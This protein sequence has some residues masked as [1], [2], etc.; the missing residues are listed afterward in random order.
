VNLRRLLPIGW[1][2]LA[3]SPAGAAGE[4][5]PARPAARAGEFRLPLLSQNQQTGLLTGTGA[6]T[7]PDGTVFLETARVE[8]TYPAGPTNV[9]LVIRATRCLV[10]LRQ[11]RVSSAEAL[12]VSTGDGQLALE[13]VG[14]L[15]LQATSELVVSNQ[16]RTR[17]RKRPSGADSEDARLAIEAGELHLRLAASQVEFRRRVRVTDPDLEVRAERLTA[18]R[19]PAGRFDRLEVGGDV[20]I[21]SRRDGSRTTS[22]RA[23]YRLTAE[24]EVVELTGRPHWTDSVRAA[25][26][27]RFL[28]ERDPAADRQVLRALGDAWIL[29]PLGTHSPGGWPLAAGAAAPEPPP[30]AERAEARLSAEALTL[31]LPPTPGPVQ[32]LRAETNVV[33][34]DPAG[35]WRATAA[36]AGFT[37]EVLELTGDPH[38]HSR[39]RE[40]RGATL[41]LNLPQRT[42]EVLGGAR[43]RLPVE[44]FEPVQ[45]GPGPAAGTPG[46]GWT[47]AQ[48]V[49]EADTARFREGQLSFAPPVRARLVEGEW[50]LGELTC[51]E[52]TVT[53]RDRLEA[54][55]AAGAVR[56]EQFARPARPGLT[57]SLACE[58]LRVTFAE[59][60][61][62]RHLAADGGVGAE[63]RVLRR[64]NAAP[65]RTEVQAKQVEAWFVPGTNRLDRAVATGQVRVTRDG[66]RAEGERVT[67]TA[68]T[69][70]LELTGTPRVETSDGHITGAEV[71]SWDTR[72]NRAGGRG[73]YRIV[74][75]TP[76]ARL[77]TNRLALPHR[78]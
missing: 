67:Y 69:G 73:A 61:V 39:G 14:F 8:H 46:A 42:V 70:V 74:W 49:I 66:R 30:A 24:G 26:A 38:W 29:L 60:G 32:G 44:A 63:Q 37:N 36:R 23:E 56:L 51:R 68:T 53:Y 15:W 48:V 13:G 71:L 22:E 10:D 4:S 34:A 78:R 62:L 50:V 35:T 45:F 27:D 12:Q 25:A 77:D 21:V 57:R 18:R 52:L 41:R 59:T 58:R 1:L 20:E 17:L 65:V 75:T 19:N 54:I 5:S 47:N 31:W 2:L 33:I 55:E 7:Q 40:I 3:A 72:H 9:Q 76:P 16:V 64:P 6:R 43:L 28:L 11:N